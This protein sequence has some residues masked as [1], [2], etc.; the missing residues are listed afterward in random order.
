MKAQVISQ[1]V[2]VM[3][4]IAF[5][6]AVACIMALLTTAACVAATWREGPGL[7]EA[8]FVTG[9]G[10]AY[11]TFLAFPPLFALTGLP[12]YAWS[13]RRGWVSAKLYAAVGMSVS[14]LIAIVAWFEMGPSVTRNLMMPSIVVAG[15]VATLA[16]WMVVRPDRRPLN[17]LH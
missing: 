6:I 17:M 7:W 2:N 11:F 5:A 15:T 4:A 13:V 9:I 10:A 16:F 3:S 8:S 14:C 1:A 12:L